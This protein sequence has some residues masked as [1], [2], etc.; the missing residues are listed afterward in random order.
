MQGVTTSKDRLEQLLENRIEV[1]IGEAYKKGIL[2]DKNMLLGDETVL[3][4]MYS[5]GSEE[6]EN[7]LLH[8]Y[9]G[10]KLYP[11]YTNRH[12]KRN[13]E[14][15]NKMLRIL[16]N[17]GVDVTRFGKGEISLCVHT[18]KTSD[19]GIYQFILPSSTYVR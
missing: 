6:Y 12:N 4:A 7:A 13:R 14:Q 11:R 3:I 18:L 17:D 19:S 16:A 9:F 8:A 15:H 1:L 2:S 5:D 10:D